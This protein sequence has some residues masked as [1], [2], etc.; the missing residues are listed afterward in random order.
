MATD[1]CAEAVAH[2]AA[3]RSAGR[4]DHAAQRQHQGRG[5]DRRHGG[6]RILEQEGER[7]QEHAVAREAQ[8]EAPDLEPVRHGQAKAAPIGRFAVQ[9]RQHQRRD[10]GQQGEAAQHQEHV[11][12]A[13]LEHQQSAA[14]EAAGLDDADQAAACADPLA[15]IGAVG[16]RIG[17][18]AEIERGEGDAPQ[19][20]GGDL[21]RL[22]AVQPVA[23]RRDHR[24]QRRPGSSSGARR[25]A[26]RS[27]RPANWR[28]GG[29]SG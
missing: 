24:P 25:D 5:H 18:R 17:E 1:A 22:A 4:L 6:H 19:D 14:D 16:H 11:A 9:G 15:G 8:Q 12:R 20:A 29:S 21:Q 7:Q 26:R 23:G 28:A 2:P 10:H 3:D 27:R 13:D